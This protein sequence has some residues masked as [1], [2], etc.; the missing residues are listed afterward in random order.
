MSLQN[1][2]QDSRNYYKILEVSPG[3]TQQEIKKAYRRLVRQ[4]HPDLHPNHPDATERFRAICEAYQVL[5]DGVKRRQY[6][7]EVQ[8][9]PNPPKTESTTAQDFYVRAVSKALAKNYQGAVKDCNQAISRNPNFVEAYV[10]RGAA[11]YNLGNARGTLQDCNQALRINSQF[12]PAYYYQGRARYRLGYTQA[13]IDAYTQAI[14]YDPQHAKAYYQRGLAHKDLQ[15]HEGAIADLQQAAQ[16][17]R[18]QGDKTGYQLVQEMLRTLQQKPGKRG[19]FKTGNPLR[20]LKG[21][22]GDTLFTIKSFLLNPMGGLLPSFARLEAQRAMVV[23]FLLA[24]I[25]D[26]CFV[27][28]IYTGWRDM[29]SVSLVPLIGVGMIPFIILAAMSAIARLIRRHPGSVA[30][31]SFLAGATVMPLTI[32]AIANGI[33]S[34]LPSQLMVMI[35]VF[36]SC[37]TVLTLYSGCTQIA[38]FSE[39][40]AALLVPLMILVSGWISYWAFMAMLG[41]ASF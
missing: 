35:S 40:T 30:G 9:Q 37:Y 39:K 19:G 28:G 26:A 18:E 29:V 20:Y 23:G 21:L 32:L 10:E 11:Y 34:N 12:A 5:S 38:N 31:D 2:M 1:Q 4:Y 7:Q 16:L 6:D 8:P 33:S 15:E 22:L 14:G 3:A 25:F 36:T 27:W 13:A 24:V 17:L 41:M